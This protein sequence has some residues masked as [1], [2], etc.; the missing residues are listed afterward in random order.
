M[1]LTNALCAALTIPPTI[2]PSDLHPLWAIFASV[3]TNQ[4]SAVRVL[5][6]LVL[7][8]GLNPRSVGLTGNRIADEINPIL[9]TLISAGANAKDADLLR[10]E[11]MRCP[12]IP[13]SAEWTAAATR[14]AQ[15][16]DKQVTP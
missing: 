14:L 15:W 9:E 8:F 11:P 6:A 12:E 10:S 13:R 3:A 7:Y 1:S 2:H 4:A 16:A 5:V